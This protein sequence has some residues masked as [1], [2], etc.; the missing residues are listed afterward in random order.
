MNPQ[1]TSIQIRRAV[2]EDLLVICN[3]AGQLGY[4]NL[5]EKILTRLNKILGNS[6]QEILVAETI[7]NCIVGYI[8]LLQQIVIE[9]DPIVEVG[10]L[11]VDQEYRHLGIGKA[12]LKAAEDWAKNS[13]CKQ[14]RLHS[15]ITRSETHKFY[16]NQGYTVI[17]TQHT[18]FKNLP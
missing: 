2:P 8:H 5:P 12:L 6:T 9:I 7:D 11:I 18:F 16:L 15:N 13:G 10:G 14:I 4:P 3:L 17:K 1:K